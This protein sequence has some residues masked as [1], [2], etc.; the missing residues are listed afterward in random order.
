MKDVQ[1]FSGTVC[2]DSMVRRDQKATLWSDR[3]IER[4]G[5]LPPL[6]ADGS[7]AETIRG[8]LEDNERKHVQPRPYTYF[9]RLL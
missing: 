9:R 1:H 4:E 5:S 2:D 8:L 3:L 7:N 6:R